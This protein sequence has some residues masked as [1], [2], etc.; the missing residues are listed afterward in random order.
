MCRTP[1]DFSLPGTIFPRKER[2]VLLPLATG[3]LAV[4][5]VLGLTALAL[6]LRGGMQGT[7]LV[8]ALKAESS[9]ALAPAESALLDEME[10][11]AVLYFV[12]QSDPLTGL[13][14]DRAANMGTPSRAPSSVAATGF[15]LAAWCVASERGW[16]RPEEARRF[17][18]RALRTVADGHAQEHGWLFHFVDATSGQRVWQSEASTI[19]TALFLQ[20]AIF[21]REYLRDEEV[22]RQ[23]DRIYR[24]IDWRWALDGGATLTHGW[25]PEDGFIPYRWDRFA[26]MM[27]LYLLGIGAPEH[28]LPPETWQAW[29]RDP[30]VSDDGSKF[31]PGGPLFTHQYAQAWFDFRG[32]RDACADYWQN[33]VDATLAQ[34]DWS[35]AQ[36][37]RFPAWSRDLWGLT[38]SDSARGYRSWG[39]P[40]RGGNDPSDGT[41]VPCAPGGSLPFAPRECLA[42]L[43][44][45]REVGGAALWGRYG[46]SDAFNPQTGWVGP[47]VIGIDVGIM[48]VM[49]ENLRSGL[50]WRNFMRAPEVRRGMELAGFSQPARPADA[51]VAQVARVRLAMAQTTATVQ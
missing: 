27:G 32:R 42:S 35:A 20:G 14:H 40:V 18:V 41:L 19:D 12:E 10:R 21:A 24:R 15:A 31:V 1:Y 3:K 45:M 6:P 50:V 30:V 43:L 16:L 8:P 2:Q 33:S 34:R 46:F 5:L 38:A 37:G 44:R 39:T 49:A 9:Y 17:A 23:V 36:A 29:R 7:P 28:P 51:Q 13:T 26:E 25:R 48:L 47:D 11:R 22:T 4:G